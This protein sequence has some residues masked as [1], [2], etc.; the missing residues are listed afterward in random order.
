MLILLGVLAVACAATF[1]VLH[2]EKRQEQIKTSGET[3]LE[4][5]TEDVDA[6]AWTY[7]GQTLSFHLDSSWVYDDDAAFPVDTE[8]VESLLA[9]FQPLQ[10]ALRHRR[11]GGS[12][13]VGSG[14]PHLHHLREHGGHG[15]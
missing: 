9:Q 12:G 1:G 7:E 13:A 11:G 8:A 6:L 5:P 14:R 3:I 4:I 15:L 10:A 2:L